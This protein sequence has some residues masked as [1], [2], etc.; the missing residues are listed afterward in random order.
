MRDFLGYTQNHDK[1][2]IH[3]TPDT[4][5]YET[6]ERLVVG[7]S[8]KGDTVYIPFAG[9]GTEIEACI[10]NGRNWLATETENQY[11]KQ[12]ILPRI[13]SFTQT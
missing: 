3:K 1:A 7:H 6:A 11:I 4:E 5:K 9:S 13:Q 2:G 10:K 8:R 12:F